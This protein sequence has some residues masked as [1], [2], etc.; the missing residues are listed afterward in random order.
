[1]G[2]ASRLGLAYRVSIPESRFRSGHPPQNPSI[3]GLKADDAIPS[4]SFVSTFPPHTS[5]SLPVAYAPMDLT[6]PPAVG[7]SP[8]RSGGCQAVAII[9]APTDPPGAP[10]K[11]LP[12]R[13]VGQMRS[14]GPKSGGHPGA[15]P[16]HQANDQKLAASG[17]PRATL[18]KSVLRLGGFGFRRCSGASPS[19]SSDAYSRPLHS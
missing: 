19:L 7:G 11:G 4:T 18:K 17:D 12:G 13:G 10:Y 2:G 16:T 5:A 15:E 9:L 1:M 6:V 14:D 3:A 8:S